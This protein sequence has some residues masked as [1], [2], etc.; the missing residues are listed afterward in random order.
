ME[1][2][3]MLSSLFSDPEKLQS[4]ISMASS[5]LGGQAGG[6]AAPLPPDA[7]PLSASAPAE[8]APP[9][10]DPPAQP[11]FGGGGLGALGG[12]G[13]LGGGFGGG[14]P[15]SGGFDPSTEFMSR[16]M[17]VLSAIARSGSTAVSR[18]KANLLN[19]LKPFVAEN[20]GS[21]LDHAMR[22]VSMARMAR[23]A[24]SQIGGAARGGQD[25]GTREL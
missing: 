17:P 5:L 12:L 2:N 24:M 15:S 23:S 7:Q 10:Y 20:V 19:S 25:D 4:A 16:A 11:T 22:L 14:A 8:S 1:A 6:G 21:Q 3:D 18:E 9:A 13:G